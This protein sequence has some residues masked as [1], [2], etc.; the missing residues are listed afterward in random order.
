MQLDKMTD[1]RF[2]RVFLQREI[3]ISKKVSHPSIV[4]LFQV[5]ELGRSTV[6][7]FE[8]CECDLLQYLQQRGALSE[9]VSRRVLSEIVSA[10]SYLHKAGIGKSDNLPV[11]SRL[12]I[13]PNFS[14]PRFEDGKRVFGIFRSCQTGRFRFRPIS[15]FSDGF[16]RD[17]MRIGRIF[18]AGTDPHSG[19]AG[20]P[21][22]S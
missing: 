22:P 17:E 4:E 19:F 12:Y 5:F 9:K 11:I 8:L 2:E 20:Q 3:D 7:V 14:S 18:F 1:E 16:V 6:L 15:R 21:D 10:V 13:S